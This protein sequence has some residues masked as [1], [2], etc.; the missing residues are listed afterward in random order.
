MKVSYIRVSSVSQSEARQVEAMKQHNIEKFFIEKISGKDTNRP[1][2]KAML[3]FVRSGDTLYIH[4]LDRLGRNTK[5]LLEIVE[6]LEQKGV[7]LISNKENIDTSS[8]VGR[9]FI[10]VLS[11]VATLER[12]TILE[13]QRE[14]IAAA[15]A[16]NVYK[17]GK[18]KPIDEEKFL[19]LWEEV[20]T[21]RIS[22]AQMARELNVSRPK[23]DKVLKQRGLM[24]A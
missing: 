5:D 15:K 10:T 13:R 12:E 20:K 4:S 2:L 23:L 9:F 24:A 11:A 6:I 18:E 8:S 19:S 1:Q 16:R 21:N 17:G 22:K 14:G 7:A 3:D